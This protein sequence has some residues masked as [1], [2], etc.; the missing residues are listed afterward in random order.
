MKLL[1]NFSLEKKT[2][3]KQDNMK[4]IM[5]FKS[6]NL[7]KNIKINQ[8]TKT[9]ETKKSLSR[10]FSSSSFEE[11]AEKTKRKINEINSKTIK[12]N[13]ADKKFKELK[14]LSNTLSS[15]F[16]GSRKRTMK[17]RNIKTMFP[18]LSNNKSKKKELISK[19]QLKITNSPSNYNSNSL[20]NKWT[21]N[22]NKLF[23]KSL[24]KTRKEMYQILK[25]HKIQNIKKRFKIRNIPN[26]DINKEKGENNKDIINTFNSPKSRQNNNIESPIK[27]AFTFNSYNRPNNYLSSEYNSQSSISSR[28]INKFDYYRTNNNNNTY[29]GIKNYQRKI[30]YKN[31]MKD[32]NVL[33]INWKKKLGIVNTEIKYGADLLTN[34]D[35]Q[36]CSIRDE[37]NLIS[38]GVH[39]YK[40]SLFG[41]EDLLTAF[42]NKDLFTQVNINK[43]IEETCALL[44]LIPKI[45]LK[46]YY[47][48]CDKFISLPEPKRELYFNKVINNEMDCFDDN[49]K[50]LYRVVNFLTASFEVYNQLV[51]QVDEEMLIAKSEF[52]TLRTIFEKC[53]YYIGN[54]TNFANNMLKDYNFDKKLI[55]K[56][57][58]IL[59]NIK[60]R[61]K[62][63]NYSIYD[64]NF[65]NATKKNEK[66]KEEPNKY[67]ISRRFKKRNNL[68]TIS[69]NI[70][71]QNDEYFQKIIR[72]KK[73]LDNSEIKNFTDEIRLK[74][75]GL[76]VGKP[77][78]LIFSPL[79]TKMLKYIK[80]DSR[81][82]IIALRSTE[83]FFPIK[84][85]EEE[86]FK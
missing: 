58:P 86:G 48:Y 14:I 10:S 22:I 34:L 43:T 18:L 56:G 64:I 17:I 35:F 66:K 60:E 82:K 28:S 75:L 81:E 19:T 5:S 55:K 74:K 51:N 39:Y 25:K 9:L 80:K 70:N 30:N 71:L 31:Y 53:R 59:D 42:K 40:I 16:F 3:S 83:K 11:E 65:Y 38:D 46:D 20:L 45:I 21:E 69:N 37:I 32:E 50:L 2:I 68:N 12:I 77:M 57:K 61:L 36:F 41:K 49:V 6:S 47:I 72:I 63:E 15:D 23:T 76:N 54:L 79:M 27:N 85:S 29:Y 52:E 78:A 13:L 24:K 33:N 26:T 73:A 62:D 8:Q 67:Y 1:K 7:I 4:E 44:S 84:E